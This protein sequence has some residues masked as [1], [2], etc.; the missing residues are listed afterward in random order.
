MKGRPV[1][2]G[3]RNH[4]TPGTEGDR[5]SMKGRPVKDGDAGEV[6]VGVVGAVPSMKG[7]PVKDSDLRLARRCLSLPTLNERPSRKGQRLFFVGVFWCFH[8]FPQ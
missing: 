4:R 8:F 2:D 3:D 1:K 6:L 5:P 7:R